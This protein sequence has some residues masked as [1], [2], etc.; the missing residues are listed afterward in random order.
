MD[1]KEQLLKELFSILKNRSENE[2]RL[3]MEV[4]RAFLELSDENRGSK[5]K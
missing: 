3:V 2:I 4:V 5:A 1:K